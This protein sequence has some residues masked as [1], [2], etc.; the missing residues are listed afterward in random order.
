MNWTRG[1]TSDLPRIFKTDWEIVQWLMTKHPELDKRTPLEAIRDRDESSVARI[2]DE[3]W[4]AK[5][6]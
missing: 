2:V 5:H 4:R 6:P 3:L 1:W